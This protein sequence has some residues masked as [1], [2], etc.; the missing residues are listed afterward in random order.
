MI[1]E[2]QLDIY[3]YFQ[4]TDY[5]TI[6][7]GQQ[8]FTDGRV[9]EI[10]YHDDYAICQ[11]D[12]QNDYYEVIIRSKDANH[13]QME[14]TCPHAK[15]T[16]V[17]KHMIASILGLKQYLRSEGIQ[18]SWQFRLS[19]ALNNTPRH[20]SSSNVQRYAAFFILQKSGDDQRANFRLTPS[21][22]KTSDWDALKINKPLPEEINLFMDENQEWI[23][24]YNNPYRP[25]KPN[26]CIN[27]NP[28]GIEFFNFTI[29]NLGYYGFSSFA[30][31]L[32]M[33]AR[34]EIPVF[35]LNGRGKVIERITILTDPVEIGAA[36]VRVDNQLTIQVGTEFNGQRF[37]SSK[38]NFQL[39]S[40]NPPW[41]MMGNSILPISNPEC[42]EI[43]QL[44]P[45]KIPGDQEKI[46]REKFFHKV[47]EL[48]PIQGDEVSWEDIHEDVIPRLYLHNDDGVLRADLRFGYGAFEYLPS[49][50][51]DP[52]LVLNNPD[53]WTFTRLH[54]QIEKEADYYQGLT[55]AKYGLKHAA[56][57]FPYGTFELR[58]HTHPYDFLT[59]NIPS[60]TETG[61][62]IYGDQESL[63]KIN[64]HTP[65][66][67]LNI[68]SG[69]DWFDLDAVFQYGDQEVNLLE[70]RKAIKKG[71]RYIKLA[72]G[73]IG[74]IPEIWLER[75]KHLFSLADL[76]EGGLR[77]GK[78][79]LSLVD[80][81][82]EDSEFQNVPI[83]FLQ[84][85][86]R[87]KNLDGILSQP[88]PQGFTGE[89]RPY[90]KAGLDWLYFLS[91]SGFG[92]ILADDMGLGKTIQVLAFLQSKKERAQLETATLLVVPKSLL[93]NWQRESARFTPD[94][95]CLEYMGNF[96]NKDIQTF[97]DYDLVLTTYG[98]MLRDIDILREYPFSYAI[99]DESQAIKNPLAQSSKASRMLKAEHRLVL[100]GT[101]VEN[102][103]F[104]LWA[105][106]AF[107]N[108]GLLG[109]ID[110]F[111]HEFA[112]PI[113]SKQDETTANILKRM[114]YPFI[115]RR[116]KKQVAPELPPRTERIIYTDMDVAQ[117]KIY[118]QTR[119]A[120]R[121][122]LLGL[123][124]NGGIDDARMKILEGLLRL[125]QICIHPALIDPTYN[126]ESIKFEILFET[127]ETLKAE[128]HKALI[129][130]QF[131]QALK[132]LE[133]EMKKKGY[134][135]SY[136]DGKTKD[137]QAVVDTFQSDP[138]ISFF[139]ISLK[140]GGVGLNLTAAD[141]VLH[142]DPWWNPAVEMQAA[143]RAH[144]IGQDKPV[145]IYKYIARQTVEEKILELQANKRKL[146]DQLISSEG[147]IF[148][149]LTKEDVQILFS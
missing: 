116:T 119:D 140:A 48:M 28:E 134:S 64:P 130:S 100:T 99:L 147:S 122:Q 1:T 3:D 133:S 35:N 83:E 144:R 15:V 16:L 91:D 149:S 125:R 66:I 110:Y 103:S 143:D 55:D 33:L 31:Y 13:I 9:F 102:N 121:S 92:G 61:F 148:K 131:V 47:A 115:L 23:K 132:L 7:R 78:L 11:V 95:R 74:P 124:D 43:L 79:Q 138:S 41:V 80:E 22:V 54:R 93:T 86:E 109:N 98:T 42:L 58:A 84:K 29:N 128:G 118:N 63:G 127:M 2:K 71:N 6:Q 4:K 76:T 62:E 101:P 53:S 39:I 52:V 117:R 44:F 129:F 40:H 38:E 5:K 82:L 37:T 120:Y 77:I 94:L 88:V 87:L 57:S 25:V 30:S 14:C 136:L 34:L 60:L 49:R 75:Y 8:Y 113:E 21:V 111:K 105:Q 18:D 81:L 85:R 32:T 27:L 146:V 26:G 141:Y 67:R 24:Y 45:L 10:E 73:S 126:K 65:T 56:N 12:G 50:K 59:R 19:L 114:I 145:F 104:E 72:D 69:I 46:F 135:F 70:V 106:F 137:R 68:S 51:P 17:C 139:L 108:P 89:L 123:I 36:M 112:N 90:Q 96:R 107:V 97:N 20:P 142:L